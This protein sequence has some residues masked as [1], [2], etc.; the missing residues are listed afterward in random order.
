MILFGKVVMQNMFSVESP[1]F[2]Y[3]IAKTLMNKKD[4]CS[5]YQTDGWEQTKQILEK[6]N[7]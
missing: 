3:D 6:L 2:H 1:A 4:N 7:E 5:S